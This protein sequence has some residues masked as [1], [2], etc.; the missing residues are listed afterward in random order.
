MAVD[1]KSSAQDLP[2]FVPQK[3]EREK[4]GRFFHTDEGGDD[5][6][7]KGNH[8]A[9]NLINNVM[10]GVVTQLAVDADVRPGVLRD[11]DDL[12]A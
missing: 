7:G 4:G 10:P 12:D 1:D 11:R 9:A 6:L 5:S 8:P 2:L 3:W